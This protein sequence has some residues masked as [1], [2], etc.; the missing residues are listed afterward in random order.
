MRAEPVTPLLVN[1]KAAARMLA[2]TTRTMFSLR[3][4]GR[5]SYVQHSNGGRVFYAREEIERYISAATHRATVRVSSRSSRAI[6][7]TVR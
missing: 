3:Q 6:L 5:I 2:I 7:V 4:S 1:E